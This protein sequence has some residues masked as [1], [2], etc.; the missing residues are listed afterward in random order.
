MASLQENRA[1]ISARIWQSIAESNI[2]VDSIP[3]DQLQVLVTS[4]A[5]GVLVAIDEMLDDIGLPAR[6]VPTTG[7]TTDSTDSEE[8][9]L[10]EGRPFLSLT[11]HYTVTTER[12]RITTGLL[13]KD[14][15]DIELVRIEDVDHKQNL[16]ERMLDL[17]DVILHTHDPS[18]PE[19]ILRNI[20]DPV[21][22]HEIIRKAMLESRRRNRF[23]FQEEM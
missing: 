4:I 13:G 15:D 3:K 19:A 17:G 12:I 11:E 2:E 18:L 8:K 23:S 20:P 9:V 22:V 21:A 1:K 7:T 5:D 10:W 16:G 14:R 6:T